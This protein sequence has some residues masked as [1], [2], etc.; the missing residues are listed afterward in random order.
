MW[1]ETKLQMFE[2][3]H[4]SNSVIRFYCVGLREEGKNENECSYLI[5]ILILLCFYKTTIVN[6]SI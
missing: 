6:I 5:I 2:E 1:I 4:S 3:R